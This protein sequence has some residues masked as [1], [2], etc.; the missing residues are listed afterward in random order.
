MSEI[1]QEIVDNFDYIISERGNTYISL[2]KV[3]WTPTSEPKLD[4]RKYVT[5][6]DGNEQIQ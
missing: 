3:K 6:S 2:R 1:S 5:K 4:L